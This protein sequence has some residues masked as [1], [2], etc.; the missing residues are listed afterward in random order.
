LER[1]RENY[2]TERMEISLRPLTAL[3]VNR[4]VISEEAARGIAEKAKLALFGI[5]PKK[6]LFGPK[7]EDLVKIVK[8]DKYY[9]N[10]IRIRGAYS[11]EYLKKVSTR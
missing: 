4:A 8:V 5:P 1:R 10:C 11:I 7:P 2:L 9:D 6:P 3:Y